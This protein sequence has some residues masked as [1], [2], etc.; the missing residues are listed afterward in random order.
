MNNTFS[1]ALVEY[2]RFLLVQEQSHEQW[3][4]TVAEAQRLQRQLD[5][6]VQDRAELETKLSHARR[7]VENES[8]A[9]RVAETERDAY[10]NIVV[11]SRVGVV[12]FVSIMKNYCRYDRQEKKLS[13]LGDFLRC[14]RGIDDNTRSKLAFL[15]STT[16]T[17]RRSIRFAQPP[18][19]E[20]N[21]TGSF[22]SDLSVTQSEDDFLDIS[23]PFKR[24]RPSTTGLDGSFSEA[25]N[26]RRSLARN[27][28]NHEKRSKRK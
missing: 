8:R 28:T 19:N 23:K 13:Q 26:K 27:D 4:A 17:K 10:V 2:K 1:V 15:D 3:Q 24:H 20:I 18:G 6:C 21:S 5:Q 12:C 22:L 7:L 14:D 16:H 25:R 11:L 9:R